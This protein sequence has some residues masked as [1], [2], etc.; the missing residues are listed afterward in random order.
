MTRTHAPLAPLFLISAAAVGFEIA[1]TRYFSIASW[2]EYGYWI[3]SITMV[4]FAVSGVV[5]SLFKEFFA[6]RARLLL[7][8]SP[9]LLMVTA[10]GGYYFTTVVPFN[11]LEFQ[12]PDLWFDQLRNI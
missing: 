6:H 10:S 11:P 12:N 8:L 3:I 4:G 1:L 7:F 5:L 2:S 9:L